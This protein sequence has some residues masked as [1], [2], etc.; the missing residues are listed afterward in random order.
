MG[1]DYVLAAI[2]TVG[3]LVYLTYTLLRPER[4]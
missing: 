1:F 3:L 2:V 4:F